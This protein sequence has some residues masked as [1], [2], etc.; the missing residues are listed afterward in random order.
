MAVTGVWLAPGGGAA[1][2]LAGAVAV[3]AAGAVAA[4]W[5]V[6]VG[7]GWAGGADSEAAGVSGSLADVSGA[8]AGA[9]SMRFPGASSAMDSIA[10]CTRAACAV[11]TFCLK[12][13]FFRGGAARGAGAAGGATVSGGVGGV[14]G[15]GGKAM[16]R[17]SNAATRGDA[18]AVCGPMWAGCVCSSAACTPSTPSASTAKMRPGGAARG[19]AEAV[20]A[21]DG[22]RA[23]SG[24]D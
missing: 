23:Q 17:V 10:G 9:S 20:K 6:A 13:G 4:G 15:V 7:V 8:A 1:A 12:T 14:D 3:T 16:L 21:S 19:V 2:A 11:A 5:A 24:V 22:M 18:G